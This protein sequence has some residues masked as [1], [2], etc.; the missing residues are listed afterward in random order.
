MADHNRTMKPFNLLCLPLEIR[1]QIYNEVIT[2]VAFGHLP[3]ES[4]WSCAHIDI[5]K[6]RI[7][8]QHQG[9]NGPSMPWYR[10]QYVV[11]YV[12]QVLCHKIRDEAAAV[13]ALANR[14]VRYVEMVPDEETLVSESPRLP[15]FRLT[16]IWDS[17][18]I[19]SCME[20]SVTVIAGSQG[21][22]VRLGRY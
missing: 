21:R 11:P 17:G 10:V 9:L 5:P 6:T 22:R 2:L 13:A 1:N 7:L 4:R 20:G 12:V 8:S 15:A 18:A 14:Q 16:E 19:W 3:G